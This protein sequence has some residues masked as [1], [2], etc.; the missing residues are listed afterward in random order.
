MEKYELSEMLSRIKTLKKAK[1][2]TNESLAEKTG[3]SL[4]TLSKILAGVT[5]EPSVETVI[6][7]AHALETTADFLIF[8]TKSNNTDVPTIFNK[9]NLLNTLGKQKAD[10]Y[11]TDLS[12]QAKY[13]QKNII[14]NDILHEIKQLTAKPIRVK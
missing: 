13:T 6:K 9:Y 8:G 10:E 2:I 5:K 1:G 14:E 7:I 11:I 3:I 12:E 4:G